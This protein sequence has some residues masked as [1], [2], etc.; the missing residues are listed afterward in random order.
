MNGFFN[1]AWWKSRTQSRDA[2]TPGT[3]ETS[4][5]PGTPETPGTPGTPGPRDP[6][7]PRDL[8]DPLELPDMMREKDF[9]GIIIGFVY[10]RG[11]SFSII[12]I[13]QF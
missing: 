4:G 5:T 1:L 9:S 10:L 7:D 2:R 13:F 11:Y 3:F 6:W 12:K 8:R